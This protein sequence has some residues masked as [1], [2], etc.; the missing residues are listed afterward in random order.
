MPKPSDDEREKLWQAMMV[1]FPTIVTND[2]RH[3]PTGCAQLVREH[4]QAMVVEW[5]R[6]CRGPTWPFA[7]RD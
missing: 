7:T 4:A 3:A 6:A 1:V 2:L 5:E